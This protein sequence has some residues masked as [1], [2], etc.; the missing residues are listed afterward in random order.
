MSKVKDYNE[1]CLDEL[2]TD[3]DAQEEYRNQRYEE[4]IQTIIKIQEVVDDDLDFSDK[5]GFIRL[6][7]DKYYGRE[8]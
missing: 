5:V 4:A 2:Y 8:N 3:I 6:L 7:C 1:K